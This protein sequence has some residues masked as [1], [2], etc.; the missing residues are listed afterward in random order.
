V[1]I[2]IRGGRVLDPGNIDSIQDIYIKD[3]LFSEPFPD[4]KSD[5][6]IDA[7]GLLVTPGLIDMHVHL[8]EPGQEYKETIETG[9][10]AAVAGGFTAVCSM[11]N[12]NPVNDN[13][14]ITEFIIKEAKNIGLARVYPVGAISMNLSGKKMSEYGDLKSAGVIALSDDGMPVENGM[15]M[16]RAFEYSKAFEL[17]L[18]SHCEDMNLAANGSMNESET[19]TKLGLIG[20]PNISESLVVSRDIGLC[21]LTNGRIHIAH[22]STKESV[23]VIRDAKQRGVSVTC[24]TAPHYFTLTDKA[25]GD[26]DTHAKM[27][28]PLRSE[29][30]RLAIIEGLKDGTIDTIATDHA[31][32]SSLEKDVEFDKAANGIIGLETSLPLSLK[33]VEDG[34]LSL[35]ELIVKMSNS[36]A[37]ILDI[38]NSVKFGNKA[39]LTLIDLDNEFV[40]DSSKF[41]SKS[42]NTPFNGWKLKGCA[43]MTIVGGKV[44]FERT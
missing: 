43:V 21:E 13:Y 4:N 5:K 44:V 37:K 35:S 28:P 17:L 39:D 8:R 26:Y 19:S 30:D 23:G 20:I 36:P 38:D 32:H 40:V 25:V 11:P 14:Q 6:I 33:L 27:N 29:N 10:M 16:R 15:L 42:K 7:K 18:I 3:D 2:I 9:T 41:R 31:P 34:F 12:T 24:E 1:N 22:V